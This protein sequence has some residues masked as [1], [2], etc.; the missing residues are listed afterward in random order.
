MDELDNTGGDGGFPYGGDVG[1]GASGGFV[2]QHDSI[3]LRDVEL[4]CGGA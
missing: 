3:E 2:L 4:V 1:E